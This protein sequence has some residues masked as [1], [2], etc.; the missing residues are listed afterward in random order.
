[1]NY[2]VTSSMNACIDNV[3]YFGFVNLCVYYRGEVD[4]GAVGSDI[5]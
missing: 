3:G 5:I 2:I 1:M 4:T